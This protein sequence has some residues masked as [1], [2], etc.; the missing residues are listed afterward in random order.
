MKMPEAT[1][2][3]RAFSFRRLRGCGLEVKLQT[4]LDQTRVSVGG[5]LAEGAAAPR[6]IGIQELGVIEGIEKFGPELNR[7]G[8]EDLRFLD[9][10]KVVV[11][12]AWAAK[13]IARRVAK[14]EKRHIDAIVRSGI[15]P[16]RAR[17]VSVPVGSIGTDAVCLCG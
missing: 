7:L 3:P 13:E 9:E 2:P 14:T 1:Q 15:E 4:K 5:N 16:E 11:V 12:D 17:Y 6:R 10:R 8:L